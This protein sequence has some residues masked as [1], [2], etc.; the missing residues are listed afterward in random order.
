MPLQTIVIIKRPTYPFDAAVGQN[1]TGDLEVIITRKNPEADHL[2][3]TAERVLE[4]DRLHKP[5]AEHN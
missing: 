4:D 2:R 5:Q 1:E 3:Q